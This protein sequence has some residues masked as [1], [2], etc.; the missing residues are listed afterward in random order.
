MNSLLVCI[1]LLLLP[2]FGC[3]ESS[4]PEASNVI[5]SRSVT[6]DRNK[7]VDVIVMSGQEPA[8]AIFAALKPYD[9]NFEGRRQLF[10]EAKNDH[11]PY[12]REYA[13][14]FSQNVNLAGDESFSERFVLLDDGTEPVDA[15]YAFAK[16]HSIEALFDEL[17]A[18]VLPQL[19]AITRCTRDRPYVFSKM[20]N[21]EDGKELGV[22]SVLLGEEPIDVI[23]NFFQQQDATVASYDFSLRQQ[24]WEVVCQY[25]KCN[26]STPVVYRK[27]LND[28]SGQYIGHLEILE[29][30][31]AS[32]VVDM[33]L[34]RLNTTAEEKSLI[35]HQIL[36]DACAN[37]RVKCTMAE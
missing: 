23:D 7:N 32:D 34:V 26:R 14:L 3:A 35:K 4:I 20:I 10:Q 12:T 16:L 24:L 25:T 5:W 8:D 37:E 2:R 21:E 19:C 17:S 33:L 13:L 28:A 31:D 29:N 36:Q 22:L 30:G 1:A 27:S 18:A 15:L 6:I 11:I 9:V